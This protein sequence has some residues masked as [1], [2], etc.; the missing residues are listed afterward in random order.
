MNLVGK[1][2]SLL[3]LQISDASD[4]SSVAE[5]D[6]FRY[7]VSYV[8]KEISMQEF[9]KYIAF[10]QT[11]GYVGYKILLNETMEVVGSSCFMDIRPKDFH[12]E[13]GMTWYAKQFRGTLV[14]PECKL[15]MLDHAFDVLDCQKVTLK[16]DARNKHSRRA[17]EKLGAI[18]EGTL[19][20]HRFTVFEEFRDTAY[21]SILREEYP[22]VR[23]KLLNRLELYG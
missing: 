6:F 3:P 9:E 15:L 22:A 18:Y 8:P 11:S 14:N 23:Q 4:L 21:Y 1:H 7:Y 20:R 19:R 12:V 16:G 2:V 10:I 13:I 5:L 17:M